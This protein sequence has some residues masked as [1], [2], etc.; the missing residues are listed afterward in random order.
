MPTI[1][2]R[3]VKRPSNCG[4]TTSLNR[5]QKT[6]FTNMLKNWNAVMNTATNPIVTVA[7]AAWRSGGIA[8]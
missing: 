3:P 5:Y 2:K 1:R 6:E 4:G 8:C 7:G